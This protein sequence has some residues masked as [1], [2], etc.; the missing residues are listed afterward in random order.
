MKVIYTWIALLVIIIVIIGIFALQLF[1]MPRLSNKTELPRMR[2]NLAEKYQQRANELSDSAMS[3]ANRIKTIQGSLTTVQ[4]K[5]INRLLDRA[6]EL[7]ANA[8]RVKNKTLKD[9]EASSLLQSC[10]AIYG[11]A[12]GICRQL[13]SEATQKTK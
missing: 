13:Q 4:E 11:E 12:N 1:T 2:I 6:E 9:T 3:M 10:Y 8:E 5:R 7:K